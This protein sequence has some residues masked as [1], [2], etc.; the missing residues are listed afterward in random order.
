MRV[1]KLPDGIWPVMLTA[2]NEDRSIDWQGVSLLSQWYL[3]AGVHGLFTVSQSSEM[4]ALS[5]AER[6]QLASHVVEA[7]RDT[8]VIAAGA[9]ATTIQEQASLVRELHQTGVSAV[10]LLTNQFAQPGESDEIWK[11]NV[12]QLLDL[13]DD[14]PLGLYECPKPYKRI[15][16][17]QLLGW[18]AQ[19]G[20]FM[21][22]KDTCLSANQIQ[23]KIRAVKGTPLKF[24]NAEMSTLL[25]SLREGGN[26]FSG[27]AANFYPEI[28][29]WL[30]NNFKNLPERVE[31]LQ[32]FLSVAEYLVED[33]YPS[34]AKY[35][36]RASGRVD[37][38]DICRVH[39]H[40][41]DEHAQR[42]FEHLSKYIDYQNQLAQHP[43]AKAS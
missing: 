43:I 21:F 1:Q 33:Y 36:L 9:F 38:K 37:I 23:S 2:F 11:D 18:A 17:P 27:V 22:H 13:T 39:S 12:S 6:I 40:T 8:P 41:Y 7:A 28:I 42:A 15:V 5:V 20:R 26:G 29:V 32:H 25:Y 34:S 10:I 16:S 24:F 4:F 19:T 31:N 14:I 30:Y 35:F 3:S